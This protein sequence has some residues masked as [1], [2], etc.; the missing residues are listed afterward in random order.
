MSDHFSPS[1]PAT[2]HPAWW[3][4]WAIIAVYAGLWLGGADVVPI[5][6]AIGT[7]GAGYLLGLAVGKGGER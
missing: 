2:K 5:P 1:R 3:S 7:A 4:M 6:L